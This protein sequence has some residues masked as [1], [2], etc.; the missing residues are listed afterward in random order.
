MRLRHRSPR[1]G[2]SAPSAHIP[3]S[4]RKQEE[5]GLT[6][7]SFAALTFRESFGGRGLFPDTLIRLAGLSGKIAS[8]D[9]PVELDEVGEG[10]WNAFALPIADLRNVSD[11][12]FFRL[13]SRPHVGRVIREGTS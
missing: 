2:K 7:L 11:T 1:S 8:D 13:S 4:A 10:S 6:S 12:T 9:E 5:T 3:L